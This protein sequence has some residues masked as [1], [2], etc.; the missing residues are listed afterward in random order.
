MGQSAA[1]VRDLGCLE[2]ACRGLRKLDASLATKLRRRLRSLKA[3]Q[4][5]AA[6]Q[7]DG[8]RSAKGSEDPVQRTG[9]AG[10]R[11]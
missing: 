5:A 1:E 6:P 3:K 11:I 10:A 9:S 7:A 4:R 2:R 8:G